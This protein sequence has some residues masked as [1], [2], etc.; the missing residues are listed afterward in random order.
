MVSDDE[1]A[2][3][4]AADRVVELAEARDRAGFVAASPEARRRFW[5]DRAR[6]AAISAY[7]NGAL[8]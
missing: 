1:Q 2:A 4:D 6:T 7:T 8:K 5:L 3:T